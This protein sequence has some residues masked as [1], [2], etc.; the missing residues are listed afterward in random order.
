MEI[1]EQYTRPFQKTDSS[2]NNATTG[3]SFYNLPQSTISSL[4]QAL[5]HSNLADQALLS[6]QNVIHNGQQVSARTLQLFVDNLQTS[7]NT[8]RRLRAF[9][10]LDKA[11]LNQDLNDEA[12]NQLELVKAAFG[13]SRGESVL[14]EQNKKS[15]LEF[16]RKRSEKDD[17]QLAMPID[18]M[19]TLEY[20]LRE[21]ITL[22]IIY[23]ITKNHQILNFNI[24][25][26]LVSMFDLRDLL[27][28]ESETSSRLVGIFENVARNN[29]T[30]S[31]KLLE[32][33]ELVLQANEF[34]EDLRVRVLS[35]FVQRVQKGDKVSTNIIE[36]ILNRTQSEK[37]NIA[38]KQELLSSIGSIVYKSSPDELNSFKGNNLLKFLR[39]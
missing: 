28:G 25:N 1:I 21:L 27:S 26:K 24:L 30:L 13:L 35:I 20:H 34:S 14:D 15:M 12:F 36:M 7:S 10:L 18:V 22:D 32:K 39:K 33:F 8:R 4:E 2:S 16:I 19:L 17:A 38:L 31:T 37:Q 5:S 6:L 11:R 9:K 23:N 3:Y 29:Q